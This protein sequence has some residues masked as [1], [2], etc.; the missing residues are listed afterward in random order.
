MG[1][2]LEQ[3]HSEMINTGVTGRSRCRENALRYPTALVY[4][5][6]LLTFDSVDM[7]SVHKRT[8]DFAGVGDS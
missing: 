6:C 1:F 2:R 4:E 5:T 3:D 8:V 7:T